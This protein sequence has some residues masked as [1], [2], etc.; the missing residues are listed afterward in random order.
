M[1]G[2]FYAM[3]RALRLSP[4]LLATVHSTKWAAFLKGNNKA[5]IKRAE[6]DIKDKPF[7]KRVYILLR[8]V[9][10]V[11]KLLRISDSNKPGMDKMFY[12]NYKT[13]QAIEKSKEA[14]D[15]VT[16][17]SS[18]DTSLADAESDALYS[19]SEDEE[20]EEEEEEVDEEEEE[21]EVVVDETDFMSLS[22][23]LSHFFEKRSKNLNHDFA[24]TAWLLSVHPDI[25]QDVKERFDKTLH[26]EP[27]E[28]IIKR[29]YAHKTGVDIAEIIN[30]FWK[31]LKLF[32]NEDG[33]YEKRNMWNVKDAREGNSAEWHDVYSLGRTEV[34]G[35]VACRT[36]SK[37]VGMGAAE[38]A[39]GTTKSIKDG[40]RKH[41]GA[42]KT[43]KLSVISSS[44]YKL[45]HAQ[46]RRE[47]CEKVD[48]QEKD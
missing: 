25:R 37:A 42:G 30:T 47:I 6:A 17:F 5:V 38:R 34:L 13:T 16:L 1:A 26:E 22:A 21:E 39:W 12:L 2:F 18:T 40:Q 43:E 28:T 11:L 14:L 24:I 19:E 44:T 15:D 10:P 31:E 48:C 32:I 33:V 3:H 9:W 23:K 29:L 4:A 46:I 8:A 27:V 45:R 35:F 7:W 36:T 41:L 20:E